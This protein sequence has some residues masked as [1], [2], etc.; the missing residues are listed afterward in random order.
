M[1]YSLYAQAIDLLGAS[2]WKP[3]E[4]CGNLNTYFIPTD[5]AFKKLGFVDSQRMFQSPEYVQ[6]ILNNH[7]VDRI[8]PSTL[9]KDHLQYEIQTNND[10]VRVEYRGDKL[11]VFIRY[12]SKSRNL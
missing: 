6:Q 4:F 7:R 10:I 11:M 12:V 9:I 8:L 2:T 5:N 3:N 1:V